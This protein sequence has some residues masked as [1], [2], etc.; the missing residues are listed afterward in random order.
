MDSNGNTIKYKTLKNIVSVLP[1]NI[2]TL[3]Q[4]LPIVKNVQYM[5]VSRMSCY[6]A[7]QSFNCLCSRIKIQDSCGRNPICTWGVS[8]YNINTCWFNW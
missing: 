6:S 7:N 8:F 3:P 1:K 5:S 4:P 2:Q